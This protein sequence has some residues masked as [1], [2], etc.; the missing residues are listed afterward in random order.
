MGVAG[1]AAAPVP[2]GCALH[3]PG[4]VTLA[5]EARGARV[6]EQPLMASAAASVSAAQ[7]RVV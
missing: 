4:R 3:A 7:A 1:A 6:V 5:P 2:P